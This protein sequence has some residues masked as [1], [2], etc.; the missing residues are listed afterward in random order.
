MDTPHGTLQWHRLAI[1]EPKHE[2]TYATLH[3]CKVPGGWLLALLW[4]PNQYGAGPSL[5]FIP[6]PEHKWDGNSLP[7]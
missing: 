7:C 4:T 3:R 2:L 6:D 5:A 1:G